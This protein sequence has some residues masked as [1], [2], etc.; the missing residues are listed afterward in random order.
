VIDRTS[1]REH[2]PERADPATSVVASAG[3]QSTGAPD[4]TAIA[5]WIAWLA[6]AALLVFL[7]LPL[8]AIVHRAWADAGEISDAT[9]DVLREALVL[10]M[11]TTAVSLVVVVLLGTPLAYLLARRHFRG[12]PLVETLVDLPMV[13]PPAVAGLA[14][15]MAFG[16]RGLVG[17]TLAEWGITIG[18]TATAVILAQI[19]VASPFYVRSARAGFLRSDRALEEAA[20]AL[21]APPARVLWAV[22][23]PLARSSLAAGAV[24][25][26]ARA[27]GEFGATIIF[28]GSFAG[29]TQTMPLA[30]YGRYQAGDLET[31]L[32]LAVILLAISMLVLLTVRMTGGGRLR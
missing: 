18:F 14:L 1:Q 27:V 6:G 16:R 2:P 4:A 17:E 7:V 29:R 12:K 21:G 25:A 28:A 32:V 9:W 3:D 31:A 5:R 11:W 26:W 8:V 19:F 20:S 23:L 24:L 30:I 22:T 15:L 10:S 13:L